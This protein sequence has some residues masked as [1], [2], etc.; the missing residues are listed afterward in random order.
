MDADLS[1]APVPDAVRLARLSV[2]VTGPDAVELFGP[3]AAVLSL[4]RWLR[5]PGPG[6]VPVA[7]PVRAGVQRRLTALAVRRAEGPSPMVVVD[8]DALVLIGAPEALERLAEAFEVVGVGALDLRWAPVER[9]RT[10]R[11][12][13]PAEPG[14]DDDDGP[15][16][17]AGSV[18]LIVAAAYPLEGDAPTTD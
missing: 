1:D 2:G 5:R 4:A 18:E 9:R 15:A 10:L 17:G 7:G 3:P 8:G 16:L 13:G 14:P 12:D 6:V 11:P